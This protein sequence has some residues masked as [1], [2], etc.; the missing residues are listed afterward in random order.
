MKFPS[1]WF[2][3]DILKILLKHKWTKYFVKVLNT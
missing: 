1:S 2:I 3:I